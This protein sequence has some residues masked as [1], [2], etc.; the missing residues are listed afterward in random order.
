MD[1]V[2]EVSEELR[3]TAEDNLWYDMIVRLYRIEN[4][5]KNMYAESCNMFRYFTAKEGEPAAVVDAVYLVGSL[6]ERCNLFLAKCGRELR[7]LCDCESLEI[8]VNA[9][10]AVEALLNAIQNALLYSPRDCEPTVTM[11]SAEKDSVRYM[12]L[13]I[14]NESS[15]SFGRESS[16]RLGF[17][18]GHRHMSYGIPI[19]REFVGATRQA[20]DTVLR[21]I[22]RFTGETAV[23]FPRTHRGVSSLANIRTYFFA[24]AGL[25][26]S[27]LR[28]RRS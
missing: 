12:R 19:I 16:E 24:A 14:S 17:D 4:T 6:V 5:V 7:F 21:W 8:A 15:V 28:W 9:R 23:F 27:A 2:L 13:S 3:R 25:T 1:S 20:E 11:S 18:F 22:F 10:H 26:L